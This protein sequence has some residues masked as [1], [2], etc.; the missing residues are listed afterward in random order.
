MHPVELNGDGLTDLVLY[1]PV[2]GQWFRVV[3]D[4]AS[5]FTYTAGTWSSSWR[6]TPGDYN[7]DGLTDL[8]LYD[9]S[10]GRWYVAMNTPT[11]WTFTTGRFSPGWTVR[12]G[13]FDGDG[14]VDLLT[15]DESSGQWFQLYADGAGQWREF[16]PGSWSS[17][18][19]VLVTNFDGNSRADVL[20]YNRASG[21]ISR[22]STRVPRSSGTWVGRGVSVRR[23]LRRV[24]ADS[25]SLQPGS[26]FLATNQMFAGRSASRRMYHG[27]HCDP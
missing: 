19:E 18:W 7:G 11:G 1:D 5:G 6:I 14:Y 10:S 23:S 22:E 4:G 13:D 3:N 25:A 8:F 12:S 24:R 26:M 21:R 15:Y 27:N 17:G 16:L 20:L 9:F 2:R